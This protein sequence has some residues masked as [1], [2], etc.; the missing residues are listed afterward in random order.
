MPILRLF[1]LVIFQK[2]FIFSGCYLISFDSECMPILRL[3]YLVIFEKYFLFSE[4][5]VSTNGKYKTSTYKLNYVGKHGAR[6]G[7]G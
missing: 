2:F 5:L 3:F 1:Y 7:R 6:R 4:C